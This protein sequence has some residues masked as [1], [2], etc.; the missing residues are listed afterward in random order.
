MNRNERGF[1]MVKVLFWLIALFVLAWQGL[2]ILQIHQA[3]W[4]VQD[5]F[6][7]IARNMSDASEADIRKKLP[8]LLKIQYVSADDLPEEFYENLRIEA[9]GGHVEI[10][11]AYRMTLWPLGPV[12]DVDEDGSYDPGRLS[13]RDYFRDKVRLDFEFE[14][15]AATP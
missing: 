5:A 6:D 13:G 8:V 10:S 15:Y 1:S 3:N 12:Q 4:K 14:P 11:S 9:G 7:G 2:E